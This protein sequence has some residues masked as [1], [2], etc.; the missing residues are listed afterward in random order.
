MGQTTKPPQN[1][2]DCATQETVLTSWKVGQLGL[3]LLST[4]LEQ[5]AAA[6]L[7]NFPTMTQTFRL[8]P[9]DGFLVIDTGGTMLSASNCYLVDGSK[10]SDLVWDNFD[11]MSDSEVVEVA[12]AYGRK[13]SEVVTTSAKLPGEA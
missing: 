3:I 11:N 4:A 9:L 6:T 13:L 12:R 2:G 1:P 10:L 8:C 5:S 7:L